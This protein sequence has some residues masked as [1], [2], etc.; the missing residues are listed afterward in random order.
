M[1]RQLNTIALS[2]EC[3]ES[4][5]TLHRSG[6]NELGTFWLK[7]HLLS[8]AR[9]L[10]MSLSLARCSVGLAVGFG[11]DLPGSGRHLVRSCTQA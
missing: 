2:H 5:W 11:P 6:L 9:S 4:H 8:A 10:T 1:T 3:I 7:E